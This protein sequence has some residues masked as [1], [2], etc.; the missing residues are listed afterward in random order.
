MTTDCFPNQKRPCAGSSTPPSSGRVW[1]TLLT[2]QVK[3]I[4]AWE[5]RNDASI[6]QVFANTIDLLRLGW[7]IL[8]EKPKDTSVDPFP[9]T[10][11]RIFASSPATESPLS[12]KEVRKLKNRG[13][14]ATPWWDTP[15][16]YEAF[17][18][19]AR[20]IIR[21][22]AYRRQVKISLNASDESHLK[23]LS[24]ITTGGSEWT[25]L[26]RDKNPHKNFCSAILFMLAPKLKLSDLEKRHGGLSL[27][28]AE[29]ENRLGLIQGT[30][31]L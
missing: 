9:Y 23:A 19:Y 15:R 25:K 14:P 18:Q 1:K 27:L 29:L 26:R 17:V 10:P 22:A 5:G 7:I 16:K 31:H 11:S 6:A 20:A 4:L 24:K 30:S 8:Q 12:D 28:L 2:K 3:K 13:N 21:T